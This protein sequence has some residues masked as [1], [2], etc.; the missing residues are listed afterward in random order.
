MLSYWFCNSHTFIYTLPYNCVTLL[1][2]I[3]SN[4]DETEDDSTH[5]LN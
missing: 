5:L 2:T 1:E 4:P 3:P